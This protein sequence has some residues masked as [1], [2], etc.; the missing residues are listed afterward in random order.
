MKQFFLPDTYKGEE[1]LLLQGKEYHY[2][3]N[4]RRLDPGSTFHG[5][6]KNGEKY[7]FRIRTIQKGR[8]EAE[9]ISS[10]NEMQTD[11]ELTLL[12]CL[13]KGKKFD[14]IVRQAVECGVSRIIPV[15]GDHSISRPDEKAKSGK[16]E[17]W[18][19]IA[20]E[21]LQQSGASFVPKIEKITELA[22]GVNS[23]KKPFLGLFFHEKPLAKKG[24]HQY[25]FESHKKIMLA[26]GPEGGFSKREVDFLIDQDFH[27]VYLG[28]RILRTETAAIFAA[29]AV[30]TIL[31]EKDHWTTLLS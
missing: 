11:T 31:L 21:A 15:I 2:L 19:K 7:F 5:I 25:L 22:L 12:Q 28:P 14:L 23:L 8:A 24:L 26:I 10:E 13:P 20:K 17:R 1:I 4:V 27:P 29:A 18:N 9:K 3:I 30:Q 6:D 16:N